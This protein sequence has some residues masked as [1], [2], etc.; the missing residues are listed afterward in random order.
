MLIFYSW[1]NESGSVNEQLRSGQ[2]TPLRYELA[3]KGHRTE[4]AYDLVT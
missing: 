3:C 4:K 2:T 1:R